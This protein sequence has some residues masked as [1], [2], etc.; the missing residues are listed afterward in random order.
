MYQFKSG[1]VLGKVLVFKDV[2]NERFKL[3]NFQILKLT[4]F[5]AHKK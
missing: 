3:K 2:M 4:F 1:Q 5:S